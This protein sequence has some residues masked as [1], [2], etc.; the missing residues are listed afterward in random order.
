MPMTRTEFAVRAAIALAIAAVVVAAVFL[1][2][3]V[4]Q[5]V[6]LA[7][8]GILLSVFLHA[9]GDWLSHHTRL[10]YRWS[11]AVVVLLLL[12][13][14]GLA[15]WLV[16]AQIAN[17][18]TQLLETVPSTF[19]ELRRQLEQT[20]WGDWLLSQTGEPRRLLTQS[21]AISRITGFASSVLW[22]LG[23]VLVIL[24]LGL[25]GAAEPTFYRIGA[26][27][28]VALQR[29]E[30]AEEVISTLGYTLRWWM[31]AR[32]AS[33]TI[34]G[35]LTGLGLWALGV[36]MPLALAL[37]AFLLEVIPNIG[38]IL[39]AV[40]AILVAWSQGTAMVAY[41]A[42]LYLLIQAA[43]SYLFLPLLERRTVRLP[44]ILSIMSV[45]LFGLI[46]GILGALVAAPLT[47]CLMVLVKMLY[48]EDA[49]GDASVNVPGEPG[50]GNA[51]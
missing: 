20:T 15:G 26:L 9:L 27:H 4:R 7:F 35:T 51:G 25:Y 16:G 45:I 10:S 48:V 32:L 3:W 14:V 24:A 34:V 47:V 13:L 30:R 22:L 23:G 17:Q 8:A 50:K 6:L 33:M 18:I 39:A 42:A 29:R 49:L 5:V 41:V 2:W 38:P 37:M 31:V 36:P 1:L 46:A 11:L 19:Q 28:L 12:V 43:E 44:P 40:P 21:N